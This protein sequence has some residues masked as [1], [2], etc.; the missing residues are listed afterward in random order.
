MFK[1]IQTEKGFQV[2]D[3][4]GEGYFPEPVVFVVE[5]FKQEYFA[6]KLA[7][8]LEAQYQEHKTF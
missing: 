4:V 6:R 1:V 2:V 8:K 5:T 7:E 3:V